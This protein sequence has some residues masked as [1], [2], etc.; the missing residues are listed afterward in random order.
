[1]LRISKCIS[2]LFNQQAFKLF[3]A[4]EDDKNNLLIINI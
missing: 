2:N 3:H 4:F 1:M